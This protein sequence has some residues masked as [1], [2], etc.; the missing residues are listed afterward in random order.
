LESGCSCLAA[1]IR[2]GNLVTALLNQPG[3]DR[4]SAWLAGESLYCRYSRAGKRPIV[5]DDVEHWYHPTRILKAYVMRE[6]GLH[7]SFIFV[8]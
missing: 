8:H 7:C 3:G 1:I 4:L 2:P 6:A 5:I